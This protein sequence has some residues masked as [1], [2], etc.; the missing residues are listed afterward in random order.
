MGGAPVCGNLSAM[1][2]PDD[3]CVDPTGNSAGCSTRGSSRSK[4]GSKARPPVLSSAIQVLL[5]FKPESGL[6]NPNS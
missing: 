5:S 2:E 6:S 4:L 1:C 3:V